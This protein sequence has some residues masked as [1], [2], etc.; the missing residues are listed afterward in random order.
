MVW[1]NP[2]G[3]IARYNSIKLLIF[4]EFPKIPANIQN[5]FKN[6]QKYEHLTKKLQGIF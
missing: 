6:Q 5:N 2:P 4:I 3:S 1:G